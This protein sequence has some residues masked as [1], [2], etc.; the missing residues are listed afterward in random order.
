VYKTGSTYNGEWRGGFRDGNG[1]MTWIDGAKFEGLW[2]IGMA[3]GQ[4]TF[5]HIDG[6]VY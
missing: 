3:S 4:G 6:D 2:E 1:T 5:V